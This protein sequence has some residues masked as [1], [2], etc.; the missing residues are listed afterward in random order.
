MA[1]LW[2]LVHLQVHGYTTNNILGVFK[3]GKYN[4]AVYNHLI[5]SVQG[6]EKLSLCAFDVMRVLVPVTCFKIKLHIREQKNM[7]WRDQRGTKLTTKRE[8]LVKPY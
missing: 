3:L 1:L 7:T 8:P 4:V 5:N 6:V 2:L